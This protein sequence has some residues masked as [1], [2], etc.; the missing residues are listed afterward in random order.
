MASSFFG[1]RGGWDDD[2][3]RR[4][5]RLSKEI[6]TLSRA[7]R[8]RGAHAYDETR[9]TAADLYDDLSERVHDMMP[10]V[11][12]QAQ[13]ARRAARDNPALVVAGVA[14]LGLALA[15]FLRR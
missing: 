15:A 3:E 14:V 6:S 2:L 13:I 5:A 1:N 8:K 4:L 12:R 7:A 11:R 9:D 10:E